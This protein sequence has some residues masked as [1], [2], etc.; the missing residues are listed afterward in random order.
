M[1]QKPLRTCGKI[2]CPSLT[3]ERY[4]TDH[5]DT[6]K[7]IARDYDASRNAQSKAFYKSKE[8]A[9][10][11]S[12]VIARDLGLC[13]ECRRNG[14][15]QQGRVVDHI[16]PLKQAWHLRL[17]LTNLQYLCQMHHQ[18]KTA[19]EKSQSQR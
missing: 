18:Q 5:K 16:Q 12:V 1:P 8:W 14:K 2:N 7:D 9:A 13:V 6:Q 4:C 15:I 19:K 3:R 11:R 10:I 17:D